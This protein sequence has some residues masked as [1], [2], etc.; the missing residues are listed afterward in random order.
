MGR[1][2][3]RRPSP[4][5]SIGSRTI[6]PVGVDIWDTYMKAELARPA[7]FDALADVTA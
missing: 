6:E 2:A 3:T 1:D 7:S 4:R 5:R